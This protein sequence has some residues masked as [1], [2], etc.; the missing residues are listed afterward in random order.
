MYKKKDMNIES[1]DGQDAFYSGTDEEYEEFLKNADIKINDGE[2]AEPV[3]NTQRINLNETINLQHVIDRFKKT[4]GEIGSGAKTLKD[5]VVSKMDMLKTKKEDDAGD[6]AADKTDDGD[7]TITEKVK[8][9]IENISQNIHPELK[10]TAALADKLDGTD[11]RIEN[12]YNN[13]DVLSSKLESI[14]SKLDDGARRAEENT[15]DRQGNYSDLKASIDSAAADIAEIKQAVTSVSKL[16]DSIFDLKNTQ[17]NTKNSILDLETAFGR[18]KRKCVLGVTVLSVLSA[19]V[20]VLEI[21]LM[22]S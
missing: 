11:A 22:L 5:T 17:Y 18:L 14:S 8:T 4:A 1:Y 7:D 3:E 15:K 19:I 9:A 10:E 16:N 21:I 2:E 6:E 20:I 13:I 12:I